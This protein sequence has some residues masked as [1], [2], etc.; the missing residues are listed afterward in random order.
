VR[1]ED[2][3]RFRK[4]LLLKRQLMTGDVT[5]M[6]KEALRTNRQ[7]AAGDLSNMPI[8][9]ADIGSDNYEQEFALGI[10]QNE[11]VTL[12]EIDEALE[13]IDKG[14]YGTCN[15]CEKKIPVARLKAKPHAELCI[16]CK[17]LQ[18]KGLL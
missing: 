11:E 16:E 6:Q 17:K 10:I 3:D 9:M 1:K 15:N 7:D 2:K 14:T 13:R 4:V 18:E 12:R 5:T 8:H